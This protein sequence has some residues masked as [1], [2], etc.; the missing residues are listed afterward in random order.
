MKKKMLALVLT[1]A[2]AVTSLV[3]CGGAKAGSGMQ[4]LML[5]QKQV[6]TALQ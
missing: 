4:Q 1:A 3:G 5:E 2:L 6:T